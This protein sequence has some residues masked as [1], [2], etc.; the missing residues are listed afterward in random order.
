MAIY[1]NKKVNQEIVNFFVCLS[2]VYFGPRAGSDIIRTYN[3]ASAFLTGWRVSVCY[4]KNPFTLNFVRV[5]FKL[6]SI[7][8]LAI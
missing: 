3:T 1:K 2:W 8:Y 7:L 5:V 6:I 4:Q